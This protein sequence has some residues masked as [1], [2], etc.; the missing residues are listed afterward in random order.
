[1]ALATRQT[2]TPAVPD[3]DEIKTRIAA[4]LPLARENALENERESKIADAVIEAYR[5]SGIHRAF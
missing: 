4:L 3:R 1:M 5:D 2:V